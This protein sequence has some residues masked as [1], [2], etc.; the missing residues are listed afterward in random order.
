MPI[1][2]TNVRLAPSVDFGSGGMPFTYQPPHPSFALVGLVI[3]AGDWIDQVTPLFAEL[4]EDGSTGPELRGPTFGGHGGS[5]RELRVEAGC[6]VTGL[7]TRSGNFVDAVR[8]LQTRWDGSTLMPEP[9][10]TSWI[11][12]NTMGG[13]ERLERIVEPVGG[14]VAIGIAGRAG[15]YIDNLTI[16]TAELVR[17][18]GT[19]LARTTSSTRSR[20][21]AAVQ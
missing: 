3:R 13:V 16:M 6:V 11:G 9:T 10:W 14:A 18:P 21:S 2:F 17:V 19:V 4:L 15:R 12:G 7:Q 8:L 5:A 20:T 1:L